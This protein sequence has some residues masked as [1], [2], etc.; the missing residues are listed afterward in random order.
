MATTMTAS[1]S[2]KHSNKSLPA[3]LIFIVVLLGAVFYVKPLLSDVDSLSLGRDDKMQQKETLNTQLQNL[4]N[5]QEQLKQGSEVSAQTALNAIPQRFEQDK[6]IADITTI[7]KSNDILLNSVN[8]SMNAGSSDRVKRATIN[9]NLT[10]N[11]GGLLDFLK[12]V[13]AN[14]RKLTVKTVSVQTGSTET[15]VPRVNFNVNM[16]TYYLDRL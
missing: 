14:P 11:L 2:Q 9:A 15:G 1:N 12:G 16:E 7:A 10:S 6:L 5:I 4:Q 3:L 13:E 8:F